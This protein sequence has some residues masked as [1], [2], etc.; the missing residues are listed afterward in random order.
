MAM[1]ALIVT[2]LRSR[3]DSCGRAHTSPKSTSS[4]SWTSF[5]EK[6]PMR[7][8]AGVGVPGAAG[9]VVAGLRTRSSIHRRIR[10]AICRLFL[11]CMIMWL[12][13]RMPLSGGLSIWA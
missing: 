2:R 7:R 4:V 8:C 9:V 3:G 5:G 10:S 6:S 12:L 13:P 11:S 1:S